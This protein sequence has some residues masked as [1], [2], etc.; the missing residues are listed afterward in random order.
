MYSK[1]E[2]AALTQQFWTSLGQYLS[3]IPSAEGEKI[4]WVNYKTGEK[5]IRFLMSADGK[6]ARI[7]ISLSHK[8]PAEQAL[9]FEKFQSLRKELEEATGEKWQWR[10]H[11][12]DVF[13]KITSEIF[14][15]LQGVNI[16]NKADWPR[17]I[18]FLK[19]RIIAL[20]NFWSNYK[21]AFDR[22]FF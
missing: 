20:D 3:P 14:I 4:N 5:G 15:D 7:A 17:M 22:S 12:S 2:A 1:Q 21:Y 10:L 6:T 16:L 13:G 18:T 11:T 19:E 9:Y 8:D